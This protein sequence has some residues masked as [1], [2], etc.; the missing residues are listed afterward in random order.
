MAR[1]S[2]TQEELE[3]M[4]GN[5][6][7]ILSYIEKL[8]EVDTDNVCATSHVFPIKN[9]F[10]EDIVGQSLARQ[11]VLRNAPEKNDEMFKVPKVL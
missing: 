9:A 8:K 7:S 1:L 11:E 6:D 10:R 2:L 4:T 5:L 3:L